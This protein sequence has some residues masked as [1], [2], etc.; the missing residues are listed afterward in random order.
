ML[1]YEALF[2]LD[3]KTH[4]LT[5][6]ATCYPWTCFDRLQLFAW[7]GKERQREV[8]VMGMVSFAYYDCDENVTL[9]NSSVL[10]FWHAVSTIFNTVS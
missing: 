8:Y 3:R 5:L 1:Y 9:K 4:V 10:S 2:T 7:T 6:S